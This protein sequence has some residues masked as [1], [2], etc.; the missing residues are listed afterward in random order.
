MIRH[1]YGNWIPRAYML[2]EHKDGDIIATFLLYFCCWYRGNRGWQPRYFLRDNSAAEQQVVDLTFEDLT[3]D[4]SIEHFLYY[5]HSERTFIK[6]LVSVQCKKV[7]SHLY[8]AFYLRH[9]EAEYKELILAVIAAI[10]KN[11]KAYIRQE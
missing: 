3:R 9:T 10:P 1:E 2:S 8:T 5:T 6:N 11:K 4:N 7:K